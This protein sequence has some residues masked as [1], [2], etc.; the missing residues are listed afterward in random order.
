MHTM[1]LVLQKALADAADPVKA[2]QMQA[3]AKTEQPFYGVSAPIRKALFREAKKQFPIKD[4]G[5]YCDVV[6]Q[7]WEGRTR[8]EMYMGLEVACGY[9]TFHTDHAFPFYE[10]LFPRASNWD[11]LDWIAS[12]LISPLVLKNPA[13]EKD[14]CRWRRDENMWIRRASLL[15]HLRHGKNTNTDLLAETIVML[16]HEK[17]F[18]VRKAIGWVL[19][20]YARTNP[21][22]VRTF[23]AQHE[24][25]LSGLSKREALK[26]IS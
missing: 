13:R 18:F 2:P 4:F 25:S 19:R 9:K 16:M 7:L 5:V 14:L 20:Q 1:T 6:T 17:E 8:E 24:A 11:T 3:Y 22:W 23:V 15:A 10:G 26:H 21:H 12:S